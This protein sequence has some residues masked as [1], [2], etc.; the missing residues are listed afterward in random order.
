MELVIILF[1]VAIGACV[2]A[3]VGAYLARAKGR[4]PAEGAMLGLLLGPLG[5]L[6]VVLLPTV[7]MV[8]PKSSY[9]A[10]RW[11]D[12]P[13]DVA[14]DRERLR[15]RDRA[16]DRAVESDE[17]EDDAFAFLAD[18]EARA[19][20]PKPTEPVPMEAIRRAAGKG[21]AELARE[22]EEFLR[23]MFGTGDGK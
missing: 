11:R 23:K 22:E 10:D 7:E 5:C 8:R 16:H 20:G 12:S 18:A 3:Y 15:A 4:E 9:I 2:L 17:A 21:P 14:R 19:G 13:D 1:V 6:I